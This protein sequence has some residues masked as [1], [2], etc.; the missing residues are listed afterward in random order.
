MLTIKIDSREGKRVQPCKDFFK[1]SD[2]FEVEVKQLPYGDFVCGCCAIEYKATEDLIHSIQNRRIFK[3]AVNLSNNFKH[4][5]VFMEAE[6]VK[7]NNAIKKSQFVG[8][9]FSWKQYYGAI[10]SLSQICIPIV[11]PNFKAACELMSKLFIKCND[12]KIRTVFSHQKR[13][14][15]FLVNALSSIDGIAG[16]TALLVVD[17]LGLESFNDLNNV[18]YDDLIGIKGIGKVTARKIMKSI[19]GGE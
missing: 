2:T 1:D 18:T 7:L 11:V 8:Q 5:Y 14:D 6:K 9:P 12:N 3:Q 17:E 19:V 16:N 4:A 10:A 15:N 13:Y